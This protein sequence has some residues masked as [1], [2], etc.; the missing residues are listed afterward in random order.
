MKKIE[1]TIMT[2]PKNDD[3]TCHD[4]STPDTWQQTTPANSPKEEAPVDPSSIVFVNESPTELLWFKMEDTDKY[5]FL[6]PGKTLNIKIPAEGLNELPPIS[7][8]HLHK[9]IIKDGNLVPHHLMHIR[10]VDTSGKPVTLKPGNK[11]K[12]F[13]LEDYGKGGC[14]FFQENEDGKETALCTDIEEFKA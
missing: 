7:V 1:G 8:A 13:R 11:I 12:Y 9:G 4:C 3:I 6:S 14:R 10:L 5:T 2:K